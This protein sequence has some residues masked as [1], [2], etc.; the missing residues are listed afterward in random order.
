MSDG[1]LLDLG[2]YCSTVV[3]EYKSSSSNLRNLS[4]FFFVT[5]ARDQ[6]TSALPSLPPLSSNQS[7]DWTI[8]CQDI[9]RRG[10]RKFPST[11]SARAEKEGAASIMPSPTKSLW[12]D[13]QISLPHPSDDCPTGHHHPIRFYL[14]FLSSS[15]HIHM[16]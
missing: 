9:R 13:R 4:L 3:A 2:Y 8:C 14:P 1:A 15:T 5:R 12:A 6:W 7:R 10:E 16:S 11:F